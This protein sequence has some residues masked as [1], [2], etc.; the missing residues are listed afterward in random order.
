[1]SKRQIKAL[2]KEYLELYFIY[3]TSFQTISR[4]KEVLHPDIFDTLK[5]HYQKIAIKTSDRMSDIES[6]IYAQFNVKGSDRAKVSI[7][8]I[9]RVNNLT[10]VTL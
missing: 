5:R 6:V 10:T 2:Y 3:Q 7:Y 1:M 4:L 9:A 8:E